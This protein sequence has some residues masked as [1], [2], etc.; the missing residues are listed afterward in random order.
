MTYK[1]QTPFTYVYDKFSY[2]AVDF[3]CADCANFKNRGGHGCFV[4]I[5]SRFPQKKAFCYIL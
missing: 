5:I 3:D 4:T 1:H 2:F